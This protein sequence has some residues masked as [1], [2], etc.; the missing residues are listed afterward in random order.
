MTS[1]YSSRSRA[2]APRSSSPLRED[3]LTTLLHLRQRKP[4]PACDHR[5]RVWGDVPA[6]SPHTN[7]LFAVAGVSTPRKPVARG[8]IKMTVLH[9][10]WRIAAQVDAHSDQTTAG[11]SPTRVSL[12][13]VKPVDVAISRGSP[14]ISPA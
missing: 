14:R 7:R 5:S 8:L 1:C 4:S 2:P 6:Y 11:I 13:V 3:R 10:I 9:R 12:S